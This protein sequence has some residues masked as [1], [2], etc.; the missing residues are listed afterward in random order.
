MLYCH[1]KLAAKGLNYVDTTI[2]RNSRNIKI[3]Y[4]SSVKNIYHLKVKICYN[5]QM[6]A[7]KLAQKETVFATI[8][9]A[10]WYHKSSFVSEGIFTVI[11]LWEQTV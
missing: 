8:C 1:K 2:S 6:L 4:K 10:S 9:L 5:M 7:V 3:I 11:S